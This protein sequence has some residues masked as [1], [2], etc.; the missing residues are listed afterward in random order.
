MTTVALESDY[1]DCYDVWLEREGD[2]C[3]SRVAEDSWSVSRSDMFHL[4]DTLGIDHPEFTQVL[5]VDPFKSWVV[6]V[7]AY[8]HCGEGKLLVTEGVFPQDA[9][10]CYASEYIPDFPGVSY[11]YFVVAGKGAWFKHWSTEDWKSNCGDGDLS[12]MTEGFQNQDYIEV[13]CKFIKNPV[14][15]ID[16]V[17]QRVPEGSSRLL[18]IDWNP[19]PRLAGTPAHDDMLGYFGSNQG[20]ARAISESVISRLGSQG[21]LDNNKIIV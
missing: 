16:F 3:F 4:F 7:D 1:H 2:V 15:A 18:A 14:Y 10:S 20:I 6:Y 19:A 17:A 5:Y 21:T 9:D 8:A 12:P 11:R 13:A